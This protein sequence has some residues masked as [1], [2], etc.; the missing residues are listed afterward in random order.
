MGQ[1]VGSI[2]ECAV[3]GN[4]NAQTVISVLH[5]A[6]GS[7][8]TIGDP[9]DEQQD[10]IGAIVGTGTNHFITEYLDCCSNQYTLEY[11]RAQFVANT[12]FRST[13]ETIGVAGTIGSDC[14]RQ[15]TNGTIT[16]QTQFAGRDQVGSIHM[17]GIPDNAVIHG[18]LSA[19]QAVKYGLLCDRLKL[20]V[21]GLLGG[22][23]YYPVI[24]HRNITGPDNH[25]LV[26]QMFPQATSRVMRRRTV[27]L[28][29]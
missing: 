14:N 29:I 3:V 24:W 1:P 17:P 4:V 15:N 7:P 11:V 18:Y 19:G 5:Y 25:D 13:K 8:S 28:G 2:L 12:R 16:K 20:T 21:T 9:Q 27:G 23:T 6:V 22:G 26:E 10:F